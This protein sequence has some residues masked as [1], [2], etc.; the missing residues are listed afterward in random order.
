MTDR[1]ARLRRLARRPTR[2]PL[3][4]AL[5]LAQWPYRLAAAL[6]NRR[7][8]AGTGVG[9]VDVPVVCVGNLSVGGTG[10]TPAVEWVARR[11]ADRGLAVTL[12]SRGYG[13]DEALLL[14]ENLPDVPHLTGADRLALARTAVEELEPDVLVLDDGFGHRRL[15]RDFDLVLIDATDAAGVRHTL[16]RGLLREPFSSLKRAHAVVLTRADQATPADLAG[17]T[18]RVR[19]ANPGIPVATARHRPV[20]LLREGAEPSPVESLAGMT[21]GAFCGVGNPEAFRRTLVSLGATVAAMRV[22]ADHHPYT[23]I[24]VDALE[25]WAE[26][27][28]SGCDI[29]T[30]QKDAVKLRVS[31]LGSRQLSALR[32]G[33]ELLDGG[34]AV[35]AALD[36][37]VGVG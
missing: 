22:Y 21:V 5:W 10:K 13:A 23:R 34:D 20:E 37:A 25:Q 35:T 28:P 18:A 33:L 17:L 16:P 29:V 19:R 14:E 36:R 1:A 4:A 3:S 26:A 32:V 15:H 7:Y 9:R 30:T 11:L 31:H 27:L 2:G 12:L 24:D 6:R 8:D